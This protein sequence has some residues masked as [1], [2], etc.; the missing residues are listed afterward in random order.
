MGG[1]LE[2]TVYRHTVEEKTSTDKKSNGMKGR[3]KKPRMGQKAER[4]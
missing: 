4:K 2:V 3:Q 1:D